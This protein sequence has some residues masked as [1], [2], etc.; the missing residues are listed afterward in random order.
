[1]TLN[2]LVIEIN[3]CKNRNKPDFASWYNKKIIKK[4]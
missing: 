1:M 3:F 2:L 4:Y